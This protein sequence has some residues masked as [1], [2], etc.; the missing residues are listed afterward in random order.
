[1]TSPIGVKDRGPS[2]GFTYIKEILFAGFCE[3]VDVYGMSKGTP[4]I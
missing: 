3:R 4:H 1:M 2:S